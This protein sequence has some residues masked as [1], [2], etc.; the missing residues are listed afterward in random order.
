MRIRGVNIQQSLTKRLTSNSRN[1]LSY[2]IIKRLKAT[3]TRPAMITMQSPPCQPK[4]KGFLWVA[5]QDGCH[6]KGAGSALVVLFLEAEFLQ[7]LQQGQSDNMLN[8]CFPTP[9]CPTPSCLIRFVSWLRH[10]CDNIVLNCSKNN[11]FLHI[12]TNLEGLWGGI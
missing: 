9:S 7:F 11:S 1:F 4:C 2:K 12:N 5:L 3:H 10:C 8:S 6:L